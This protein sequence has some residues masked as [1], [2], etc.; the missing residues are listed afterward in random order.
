MQELNES[1]KYECGDIQHHYTSG[2]VTLAWWWC[3]G[4]LGVQVVMVT[5]LPLPCSGLLSAPTGALWAEQQ[6]Q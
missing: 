6:K 5:P 1:R 2:P 4:G 3:V